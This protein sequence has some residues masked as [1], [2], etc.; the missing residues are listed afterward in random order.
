M[1]V[2]AEKPKKV[3]I[4]VHQEQSRPGRVGILLEKRG[5]ELHRLCPKLGCN[6]PEDMSD[7]A[8][9]VIFGGP[10]SANDCGTLAGITCELEWIPKVLE[11]GVPFPASTRT[12]TTT[13]GTM[14]ATTATIP[15]K[16]EVAAAS[17]AAQA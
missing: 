5:Y 3:A 17:P 12:T 13:V 11:Q 4:V 1:T 15:I 6:L 7:Y 2:P 16:Q 9:V 8:G 10:M 14:T